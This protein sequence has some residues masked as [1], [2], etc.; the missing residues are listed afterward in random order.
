MPS[1]AIAT[2]R[3]CRWSSRTTSRF[4]PAAL[5]RA[6]RRCR[7][8]RPP[9]RRSSALSPVSI[10]MRGRR[11][12]SARSRPRVVALIGSATREQ[13][14]RAAVDG[15]EHTVCPS[16]PQRVGVRSSTRPSDAAALRAARRCRARPRARRRARRRPGPVTDSK[17]VTAG[18]SSRASRAPATI[19]AASGCSL[20]RSRLAARR[21]TSVSSNRPTGCTPTRR[22]C[23]SVSVPVLS[24]TS[25]STLSIRSSASAFLI[26]T[27]ARRRGR[28]RP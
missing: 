17:P 16:L 23:P 8:S 9:P 22:G 6:P 3:P 2:R 20:A 1:P 18:S 12:W 21:S 24:T 19:A 15:H 5:R 4:A 25:V 14:G 10:T 28:C 13:T 11:A 26:S 27:P 7:A